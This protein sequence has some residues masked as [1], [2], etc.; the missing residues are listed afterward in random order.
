MAKY[1]I[2]LIKTFDE[3]VTATADYFIGVAREEECNSS[4]RIGA[5]S[6]VDGY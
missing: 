2:P 3:A 4:H 5:V 6:N 1:T